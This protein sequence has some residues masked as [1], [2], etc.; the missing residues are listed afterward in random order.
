L[1]NFI[2]TVHQVKKFIW[3]RWVKSSNTLIIIKFLALYSIIDK[4]NYKK[5]PSS[6][7]HL[8]DVLFYSAAAWIAL[9]ISIVTDI[10]FL[11]VY[12]KGKA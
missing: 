9:W 11:S 12:S 1:H 4:H 3:L 6:H 5:L 2:V 10:Y 7:R 8:R